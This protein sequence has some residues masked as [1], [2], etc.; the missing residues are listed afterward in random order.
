MALSNSNA[1]PRKPSDE[2][3]GHM[4]DAVISSTCS[5]NVPSSSPTTVSDRTV[6]EESKPHQGIRTHASAPPKRVIKSSEKENYRIAVFLSLKFLP[7]CS[8]F[9]SLFNTITGM[10][11]LLFINCEGS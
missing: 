11:F 2:L 7:S 1:Q 3:P 9:F 6:E 8:L 10:H 4:A 5:F